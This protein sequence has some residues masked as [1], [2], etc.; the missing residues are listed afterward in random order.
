MNKVNADGTFGNTVFDS[1]NWRKGW[2]HVEFF[3]SPG[4]D[5]F[6][7]LFNK[8]DKIIRTYRVGDDGTPQVPAIA[9]GSLPRTYEIVQILK[10][11]G[12]DH[13]FLHDTT[14]AI[15]VVRSLTDIGTIGGV[16]YEEEWTP[17][18]D[19]FAFYRNSGPNTFLMRDNKQNGIPGT[20]DPVVP[21]P[22]PVPVLVHCSI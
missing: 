6:L 5:T 17:G 4:K 9:D 16:E 14:L 15:S 22:V 18:Y 7:L 3:Q 1:D 8:S 11:N 19:T 21:V 13:L 20:L 12:R 2:T 10:L